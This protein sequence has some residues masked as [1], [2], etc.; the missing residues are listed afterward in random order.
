MLAGWKSLYKLCRWYTDIQTWCFSNQVLTACIVV[1]PHNWISLDAW[2]LPRIQPSMSDPGGGYFRCPPLD[3][4]IG[5]SPPLYVSRSTPSTV[6]HTLHCLALYSAMSC[7]AQ[8]YSALHSATVH[9]TA[10]SGV[11]GVTGAAGAAAADTHPE[12]C[13]FFLSRSNISHG[14]F[15]VKGYDLCPEENQISRD[16]LV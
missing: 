4:A 10:E 16:F 15:L 9:C 3:G 6:H 11:T 7:T 14:G 1:L 12:P 13:S 5:A 8:Y 2:I